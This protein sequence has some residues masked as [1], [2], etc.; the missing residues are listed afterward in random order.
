MNLAYPVVNP[1]PLGVHRSH[2]PR[3]N[4]SVD[5]LRVLCRR[6]GTKLHSHAERGND[7]KQDFT[8]ANG[9]PLHL[10]GEGDNR[11]GKE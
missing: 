7:G 9:N 11:I 3:G 4:A 5:A 10:A 1:Q 2:A 6:S 8:R